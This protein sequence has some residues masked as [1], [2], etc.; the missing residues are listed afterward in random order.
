MLLY[1]CPFEMGVEDVSVETFI[2]LDYDE[3]NS[4]NNHDLAVVA[5]IYKKALKIREQMRQKFAKEADLLSRQ[6]D[7]INSEL[8]S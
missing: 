4:L 8:R 1:N 5:R 2:N 7:E 3:I 6:I